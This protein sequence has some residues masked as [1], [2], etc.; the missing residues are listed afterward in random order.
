MADA[1]L[2]QVEY[3]EFAA[4]HI[5]RGRSILGLFP[6]T[7]ASRAEYDT[8]VAAGRPELPEN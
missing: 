5:A 1:A 3:E 8:W 4:R 7:P 6:A 2:D